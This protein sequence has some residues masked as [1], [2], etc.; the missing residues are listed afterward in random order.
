MTTTRN[1]NKDDKKRTSENIHKN[2]IKFIN[3][4]SCLNI[5]K[6]KFVLPLLVAVVAIVLQRRS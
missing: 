1:V 4:F 5:P 6:L 3:R 2:F